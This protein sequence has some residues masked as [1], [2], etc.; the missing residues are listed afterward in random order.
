MY[1]CMYVCI[2]H[3]TGISSMLDGY[4]AVGCGVN[5]MEAGTIV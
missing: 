5:A 1:I 3:K 2:L 4:K